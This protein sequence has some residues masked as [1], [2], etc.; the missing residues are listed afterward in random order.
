M[1][2]DRPSAKMLAQ[3]MR[4]DAPDRPSKII[5]H[6]VRSEYEK[7]IKSGRYARRASLPEVELITLQI[8][9]SANQALKLRP[10]CIIDPR[11]SRFTPKWDAVA[12]VALLAVVAVS[13]W[14]R[15]TCWR[16]VMACISRCCAARTSE[17]A[18]GFHTWEKY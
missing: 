10:G 8:N 1:R 5:P 12:S 6:S 15:W 7:S 11:T 9:R 13:C 18:V 14:Q 2:S 4:S 16:G 3:S 17:N